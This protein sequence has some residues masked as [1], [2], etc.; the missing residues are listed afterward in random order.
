[1]S[2]AKPRNRTEPVYLPTVYTEKHCTFV[3]TD[4]TRCAGFH[5]EG[6]LFCA[7]HDPET[8]QAVLAD[9]RNYLDHAEYLKQELTKP[10]DLTNLKG[11][12]Q[13]N[14]ILIQA[15]IHKKV[16]RAAA[17]TVGY[18]IGNQLQAIRAMKEEQ[19]PEQTIADLIGDG[20]SIQ[21]DMTKEER[22]AFL[23]AGSAS[24]MGEILNHVKEEGRI[25]DL[26]QNSAGKF[27][28]TIEAKPRPSA[29]K[30]PSKIIA[31]AMQAEGLDVKKFEVEEY[32]GEYLGDERETTSETIGLEGIYKPGNIPEGTHHEFKREK[33]PHP[34]LDGCLI[35]RFTCLHCGISVAHT[36]HWEN[37]F[38]EKR[39]TK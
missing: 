26:K 18:L 37:L 32:F 20:I 34:K 27:E 9:H 17:N 21:I 4:G 7:M 22:R 28:A 1:M 6:K 15:V 39:M 3:R 23:T 33:V 5:I 35:D 2:K 14:S 16:D 19:K 12:V 25:I 31:E 38:C 8:K 30:M 24:K 13:F 29:I 36:S 10:H 11:L